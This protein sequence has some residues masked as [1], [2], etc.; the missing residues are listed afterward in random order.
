MRIPPTQEVELLRKGEENIKAL[1][2]LIIRFKN[3][4]EPHKLPNGNKN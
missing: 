2:V 3:Q 1:K 4:L